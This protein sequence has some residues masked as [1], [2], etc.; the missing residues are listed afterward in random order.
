[1]DCK[2]I[3]EYFDDYILGELDPTIEIQ[4]HGHL[5]EC[6]K[7]QKNIEEREMFIN[8]FRDSHKFRPSENAYRRIRS[9]I[10]VPE[11]EKRLVWALPKKF[12]YAAAAFLLGIVLMRAIDVLIFPIEERPKAEVKY[13]PLRKEPYSDTVQFYFVPAK[14]LAKI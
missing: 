6:R 4:I 7:C 5:E 8:Q 9:T 12:V 2:E 1:M 11:K 13:E 14:N 10:L 3:K